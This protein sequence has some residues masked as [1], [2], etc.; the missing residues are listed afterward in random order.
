MVATVPR[1]VK[2]PIWIS[3]AGNNPE[4]AVLTTRLTA[5]DQRGFTLV[6]LLVVSIVIVLITSTIALK[7]TASGK[8][9]LHEEARRINALVRLASEQALLQGRDIGMVVENNGYRFYLFDQVQRRWL[10][11]STE[12]L[13]RPRTLPDNMSMQLALEE[14]DVTWP[15]PED[16]PSS[17]DEGDADDELSVPTPQILM[18]S[19]GEITP[20]ELY[21]EMDEIEPAYQLNVLPDGSRELIELEYG[22]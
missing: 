14:N 1:A 8:K 9:A 11:L 4:K 21:F 18:L 5:R 16:D 10:D 6:E 15:D 13:F 3:A 12:R 2:A 17:S 19:S 20:F 7:L 22:F